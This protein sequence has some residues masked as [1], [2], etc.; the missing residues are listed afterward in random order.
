MYTALHEHF[1]RI[2]EYIFDLLSEVGPIETKRMFGGALLK[3]GGTQL[4][5]MLMETLYF[6][7]TDIELQEKYKKWGSTQFTYTRKDKNDPVIIKNWWTVPEM[8]LDNGEVMTALDREV[9]N[10]E[11]K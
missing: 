9:L 3:V 4:G 2:F 8:A 5:V 6:K 11:R 7:V 10:Q 1:K